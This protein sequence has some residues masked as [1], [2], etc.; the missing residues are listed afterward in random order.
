[1]IP[2]ICV[3]NME[4]GSLYLCWG[5]KS[6]SLEP[7]H[8]HKVLRIYI[9]FFYNIAYLLISETA[10]KILQKKVILSEG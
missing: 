6:F 4:L 8:P 9:K 5:H 3:R 2:R 1:M 7:P 10:Q